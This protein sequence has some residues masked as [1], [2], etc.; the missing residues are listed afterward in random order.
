MIRGPD[1]AGSV[2][3]AKPVR[4]G[5]EPLRAAGRNN[6]DLTPRKTASRSIVIRNSLPGSAAFQASTELPT[7]YVMVSNAHPSIAHMYLRNTG[8]IF[9]AFTAVDKLLRRV[10]GQDFCSRWLCASLPAA[11]ASF[12]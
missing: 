11:Y 10:Q 2:T 8:A 1:L 9:W 3:H 6:L 12:A 4:S 7:M 5:V